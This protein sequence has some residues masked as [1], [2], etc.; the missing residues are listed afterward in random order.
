MS[1]PEEF[2]FDVD[3]PTAVS[4]SQLAGTF[5]HVVGGTGTSSPYI[6]ITRDASSHQTLVPDSVVTDLT[7]SN[8]RTPEVSV[9]SFEHAI[10][11]RTLADDTIALL[12]VTSS[13]QPG[14]L[15]NVAVASTQT[16]SGAAATLTFAFSPDNPLS[17]D[18]KVMVI[19]VNE[20]LLFTFNEGGATTVRSAFR[21]NGAET[22][23]LTNAPYNVTATRDGLGSRFLPD[24]AAVDDL[25][26]NFLKN[27]TVSGDASFKLITFTSDD[28][29]IDAS[30]VFANFSITDGLLADAAVIPSE[31]AAGA[32]LDMM[33]EF[34]V[35]NSWP[36]NGKLRVTFPPDYDLSAATVTSLSGNVS[37]TLSIG[38]VV[39]N[40][41]TIV[42][43]GG[44]A[45]VS[46][47]YVQDVQIGNIV[48]P[49]YA[50]ATSF[51][52]QTTTA[53]NNVIDGLVFAGP[54]VEPAALVG[55]TVVPTLTTVFDQGDVTIGFTT[56]NDLPADGTIVIELDASFTPNAGGPTTASST[57]IDGTL[58]VSIVGTV[59]TIT[60]STG[61]VLGGGSVVDDL[62]LTNVGNPPAEV[63]GLSY[64]VY[65]TL[66]AGT[67]I[68]DG[69]FAITSGFINRGTLAAASVNVAELVAGDF[70]GVTVTFE[71]SY[72]L[73]VDYVIEIQ[74]PPSFQFNYGGG[75]F[76]SADNL[77]G[78]VALT[79][80]AS[81]AVVTLRQTGGT[82]ETA[83]FS[84]SLTLANVRT[85]NVALPLGA[86]YAIRSL[87]TDL[88][89]IEDADPIVEAPIAPG[90]LTDV[91]VVLFSPNAGASGT[92][93][94]VFTTQN[95]IPVD[96]EI[97]IEFP[98]GFTF[99]TPMA[100]S[101]TPAV[102]DLGLPSIA[103]A[104]TGS[105]LTIVRNGTIETPVGADVLLDISGVTN[106]SFAVDTV[107]NVHT[108]TAGGA[109][110][111]DQIENV[112][113]ESVL[114]GLMPNSAVTPSST[115]IFGLNDEVVVSFT[116]TNIIPVRGK[117][118]IVFPDGFTFN[119]GGA[120]L[121]TSTDLQ[122]TLTTTI[123]ETNVTVQRDASGSNPL[124][125][126]TVVDDLTLSNIR[127]PLGS[128]QGFFKLYTF[129]SV[130]ALIDSNTTIPVTELVTGSL[131]GVT[132]T[133]DNEVI[134]SHAN[135]IDF[136]FSTTTLWPADGRLVLTFPAGVFTFEPGMT[137]TSSDVDGAF[138]VDASAAPR[139]VI[140]RDGSGTDRAA[141]PIAQIRLLAVTNPLVTGAISVDMETTSK[142]LQTIDETSGET[143]GSL[144][145]GSFQQLALSSPDDRVFLLNDITI[146]LEL[147]T[148]IPTDGSFR[149]QFADE[150]HTFNPDALTTDVVSGTMDGTFT[151][152]QVSTSPFVF[153]VTRNGD[154]TFVPRYG[155]LVHDPQRAQQPVCDDWRCQRHR[156]CRR[157]RSSRAERDDEPAARDCRRAAD[158]RRRPAVVLRRRRRDAGHAL[159]YRFQ[160]DSV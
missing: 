121:A 160:P 81:P 99:S 107:Y 6:E 136:A 147:D 153:D 58:T 129:T 73:P 137:A 125:A 21:L 42:R 16:A 29:I 116:T 72:N 127:N 96:G 17:V 49:P 39:G 53:A 138:T 134:G 100:T 55:A 110:L 141:G 2:Q 19:F 92:V 31:T 22:T 97:V 70:G 98:A 86:N 118:V 123:V 128:P 68:I 103:V 112:A 106:P 75:T 108:Q 33:L 45:L 79:V 80:S 143:V 89:V 56:V 109:N 145:L 47:D 62:V 52:I 23:D 93:Q 159:L 88:R 40:V 61:T 57:D 140:S 8:T 111:I 155:D 12:N 60:R 87:T 124:A 4:S 139:I 36:A 85:S 34:R 156:P 5:T 54:P 157:I 78:T 94:V 14:V 38:S 35:F 90:A 82:S 115:A 142:F 10:I 25:K 3:A 135:G 76:L 24:G 26:I 63:A 20:D 95:E 15:T 77:G 133:M 158:G 1:F 64:Q 149:V 41:A 28:R 48:N 154:G 104:V 144:T 131:S 113:G 59:I 18:G 150:S 67:N 122:A 151:L 132:I 32:S 105:T 46:G 37:G 11:I 13:V 50:T 71:T 102:L 30:P 7:I 114:A 65:T 91:N 146:G 44:V 152:T 101:S 120:T 148:A 66:A 119:D 9:E 126:G 83:G 51:N 69:D 130:D 43:A 74:F 27:P 84:A 117:V